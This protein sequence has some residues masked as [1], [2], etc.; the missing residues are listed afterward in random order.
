M[1]RGQAVRLVGQQLTRAGEDALRADDC[2]EPL[3]DGAID[4]GGEGSWL[5]G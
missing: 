4:H 1:I 3:D 2:R 5:D